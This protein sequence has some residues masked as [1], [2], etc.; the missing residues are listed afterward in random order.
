MPL[1]NENASDSAL[2]LVSLIDV[3]YEHKR[4]VIVSAPA[5]PDEL[6]RKGPVYEA[7]RRVASRL[8]EMQTWL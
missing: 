1:F 8:A 3:C 7:F 4:R 5:Y 6:Y 2:R